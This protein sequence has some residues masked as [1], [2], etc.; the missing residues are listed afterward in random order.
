MRVR[1]IGDPCRC[2]FQ[3]YAPR[4]GRCSQSGESLQKRS[5][6]KPGN[7]E[8]APQYEMLRA[9]ATRADRNCT[10]SCVAPKQL[11]VEQFFRKFRTIRQNAKVSVKPKFIRLN[12][13]LQSYTRTVTERDACRSVFVGGDGGAVKR[14]TQS[15]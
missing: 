6:F 4:R 5:L 3:H 2:L 9:V 13:Y 8:R 11:Q 15:S 10:A 14:G 1:A 7:G 12:V